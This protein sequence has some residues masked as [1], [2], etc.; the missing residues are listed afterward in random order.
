MG[1]SASL[2][3]EK[4]HSKLKP[5]SGQNATKSISLDTAPIDTGSFSERDLRISK[6]VQK[7]KGFQSFVDEKFFV[8]RMNMIKDQDLCDEFVKYLRE[9]RW[10]DSVSLWSQV[11]LKSPDMKKA[12]ALMSDSITS[13]PDIHVLTSQHGLW[14]SVPEDSSFC[15]TLGFFWSFFCTEDEHLST[16]KKTTE[17][18]LST[19]NSFISALKSQ[20]QAVS[21][22]DLSAL[23]RSGKWLRKA[24][25]AFDD[26]Y[27]GVVVGSVSKSTSEE[28]EN[29]P[30]ESRLLFRNKYSTRRLKSGEGPSDLHKVLLDRLSKE[31]ATKAITAMENYLSTEWYHSEFHTD[32]YSSVDVGSQ[33]FRFVRVECLNSK[34]DKTRNSSF[35]S[36]ER[37]ETKLRWL[38]AVVEAGNAELVDDCLAVLKRFF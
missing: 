3:H 9:E 27:V 2:M 30:V 10:V 38:V 5:K 28:G 11:H 6:S 35:N 22:Q 1:A 29:T 26:A 24:F 19:D 33:P 4:T 23:L 36:L 13:R 20:L 21:S 15:L 8:G 32:F 25:S 34:G 17:A 37:E 14:S 12:K 7:L 31:Q 18:H 16:V